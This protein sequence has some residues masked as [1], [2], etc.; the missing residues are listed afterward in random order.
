MCNLDRNKD[1]EL[2]NTYSF[3]VNEYGEI[4]S[5]VDKNLIGT[6]I[7][8][9]AGRANNKSIYEKFIGESAI[10]ENKTAI[11]NELY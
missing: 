4:V 5:F 9:Y 3:I 6:N 7:D 1:K 11:I 10:L 2:I 8:D